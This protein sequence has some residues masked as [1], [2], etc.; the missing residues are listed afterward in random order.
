MKKPVGRL[1]G[2]IKFTDN[3]VKDF[4]KHCTH[5]IHENDY[6]V[7]GMVILIPHEHFIERKLNCCLLSTLLMFWVSETFFIFALKV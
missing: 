6:D 3:E 5:L 4:T 7:A 1:T 2:L